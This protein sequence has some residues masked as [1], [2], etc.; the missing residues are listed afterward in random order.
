MKRFYEAAYAVA[1]EGGWAI[2]L[3]D[4]PVRTPGRA[5]LCLPN[6]ALADAIADEWAGQGEQVDPASMALTGFAN[7]TID[8]VLPEPGHFHDLLAGYGASDLLCYRAEAPTEL[9]KR[10]A[11]QW[12][13]LLDWARARHG[14]SFVLAGGIMPVDQSPATLER[15]RTLVAGLDVWLLAG[16]AALTQI[17]GSIIGTLAHL[18]GAIA[19]PALFDA[20]SLD[21]RWQVERWGEDAEA[22]AYL[23]ER[24]AHFLAAAQYCALAAAGRAR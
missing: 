6:A 17:G 1:E 21:E 22:K 10:Q 3:D 7:A 5:M 20:T 16:A 18:D 4:R 19:A 15:L 9:A 11:D 13:P 12:D 14:L 23:D 2:R 8:R 24:R